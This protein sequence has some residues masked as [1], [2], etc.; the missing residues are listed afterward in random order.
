MLFHVI[1]LTV[2][3]TWLNIILAQIVHNPRKAIRVHK[4][5]KKN[6]D[7]PDVKGI[8]QDFDNET[9]LSTYLESGTGV[10]HFHL[11]PL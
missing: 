5:W 10:Y 7:P 8:L 6:V 9:H 11:R 4:H 2:A 1:G 3:E